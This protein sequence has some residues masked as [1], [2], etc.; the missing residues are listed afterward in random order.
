MG[1]NVHWAKR[2]YWHKQV[3]NWLNKNFNWFDRERIILNGKSIGLN[4]KKKYQNML[5]ALNIKF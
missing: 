3:S 1:R 5:I 4:D 2:E